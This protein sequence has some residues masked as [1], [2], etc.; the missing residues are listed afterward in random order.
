MTFKACLRQVGRNIQGARKK[1]GYTQEEMQDL[2]YNYRYYQKIEGGKVNPTLK[3]LWDLAK[4][5]N[6][7][8]S[9]L[10]RGLNKK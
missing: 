2:G 4:S 5:L 1:A 10:V 6:T 7:T 8:V 9:K 3:T